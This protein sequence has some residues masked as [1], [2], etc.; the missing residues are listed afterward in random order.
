MLEGRELGDTLAQIGLGHDRVLPVDAGGVTYDECEAF[1]RLREWRDSMHLLM[2]LLLCAIIVFQ[3]SEAWVTY[4]NRVG[5]RD[6]L[7]D[8][9]RILN[10]RLDE[11]E[12]RLFQP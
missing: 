8:Q 7:N 4:E 11:I 1:E 3:V 10:R 5:V 9:W 2:L 12:A 6:A